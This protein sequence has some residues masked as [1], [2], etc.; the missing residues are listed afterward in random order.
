MSARLV[1]LLAFSAHLAA[2]Q[3]LDA[4]L[5]GAGTVISGVVRDSVA[6]VPLVG[7]VVQISSAEFGRFARAS[8][9]DSLGHYEFSDVP[10]GRYSLGFLHPML[11]SLGVEAPIHEVT[12]A[13]TRIVHVDLAIPSPFRLR[14]AICGSKNSGAT[15]V[16]IV[17]D[18]REHA[19]IAGALVFAEW[20]EVSI[21]AQ[22]LA[23][24]VPHVIATTASNGWFALCGVPATGSVRVMASHDADSTDLV[25]LQT[26]ADVFVR[27]D[28]YIGAARIITRADSSTPRRRSGDGSL[29]GTVIAA[30]GGRP[31]N[32]AQVSVVNG[33]ATQTNERGEWT[34][35]GAPS[36]TRALEIRAIGYYP[37]HRAVDVGA[38]MTPLRTSMSTMK[39]VLD[40]IRIS[41]S[42]LANRKPTGFE[43]RRRTGIGH[44][45]TAEDIARFRPLLTS[46]ALRTVPGITMEPSRTPGEATSIQMRGAFG[47]CS[48]AIYIDGH[49]MH[50]LSAEDIDDFVNPEDVAG[51]EVYVDNAPAQFSTGL[52]GVGRLKPDSPT[53]TCGSIV[54]WSKMRSRPQEEDQSTRNALRE[55]QSPLVRH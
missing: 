24:R 8:I 53:M 49:F 21:A 51:I 6:G 23:R 28:L 16:G 3:V 22:G 52:A 19:P 26:K 48:P 37:E 39:A 12:V 36:G 42:R 30:A 50:D 35:T 46:H 10:E 15:I 1:V 2:A 45:I 4:G 40:T 7:A 44:Y 29:S 32:N 14:A 55:G 54:I 33:P 31:I 9:S 34:L 13:R 17:R 27:R 5:R 18:A 43:D 47:Q 11:D 38:Q 20:L 25:D 41:V